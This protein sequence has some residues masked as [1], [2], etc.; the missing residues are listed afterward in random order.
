M[1]PFGSSRL[2]MSR[3]VDRARAVS[4]PPPARRSASRSDDTSTSGAH[5]GSLSADS[6]EVIFV[7]TG[8]RCPL[9]TNPAD[10]T[11]WERAQAVTWCRIRRLLTTR[12]RGVRRVADLSVTPSGPLGRVGRSSS[13]VL[14]GCALL[15]LVTTVARVTLEREW[16]RSLRIQPAEEHGTLP[17]MAPG[18]ADR[19]MGST[20]SKVGNR[21]PWPAFRIYFRPLIKRPTRNR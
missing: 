4:L 8:K 5:C 18:R 7:S 3:C 9:G 13:A 12:Y 17:A 14:I 6:D 15:A 2:R 1:T 11:G 10:R 20:R 16:S 19:V 21:D